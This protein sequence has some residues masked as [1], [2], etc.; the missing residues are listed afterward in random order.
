[1]LENFRSHQENKE[2][3]ENN[4]NRNRNRV[5]TNK[6]GKVRIT[7][8]QGRGLCEPIRWLLHYCGVPFEEVFFYNKR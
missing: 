8:V 3:K 2:N 6:H 5:D 1:M 4:D 7:Y